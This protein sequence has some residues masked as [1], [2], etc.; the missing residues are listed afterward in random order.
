M[1]AE[2]LRNRRSGCCVEGKQVVVLPAG[3]FFFSNFPATLA[4]ARGYYGL[5]SCSPTVRRS[6]STVRCLPFQNVFAKRKTV[7]LGNGD[8]WGLG[9]PFWIFQR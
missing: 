2:W 8:G 4:R 7:T 5:H 9:T 3:F 6:P 1:V